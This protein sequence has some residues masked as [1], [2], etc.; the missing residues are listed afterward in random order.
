MNPVLVKEFRQRWRTAKT[1]L[2]ISLYL[3]VIG[4]LAF[5]FMYEQIFRRGYI[6]VGQSKNLFM[7]L[8]LLQM[9]LIAFVAPGLTSGVISGERERQ[10]LNLLLT[11]HL[12]PTS[13]VLSKLLTS[14]SFV[15]LLIVSTLPLY[16]MVLLYGGV[17]P[18]QLV[19]AFGFF[20]LLILFC[21]S[22]GILCS[23][24]FKRTS[25]STVVAYGVLFVILAGAPF[26]S[27]ILEDWFWRGNLYPNYPYLNNNPYIN[28]LPVIF[29][30]M[31]PPM[32][33]LHFF[34]PRTFPNMPERGGPLLD[35]WVSNPWPIFLTVFPLLT[36]I[37]IGLSIYLLHP[38]RPKWRRRQKH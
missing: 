2:I 7:M 8:S 13:I 36:L 27:F 16:A 17:S 38:V 5:F 4:G 11:T 19:A 35:M 9:A 6:Q 3:L 30:A 14:V 22:F 32:M 25:V 20:V 33:L 26:L 1:P 24:W 15:L 10:T 12:S 28:S 23:V 21:G 31:S 18:L 37:L 29:Q 34:E